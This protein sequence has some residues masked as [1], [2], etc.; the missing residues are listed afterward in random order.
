MSREH[1]TEKGTIDALEQNGSS[2]HTP[3]K[4]ASMMGGISTRLQALG[5]RAATT[6]LQDEQKLEQAG[7]YLVT[8]Y[9]LGDTGDEQRLQAM[10][11][12]TRR[13]GRECQVTR[14]DNVL[15]LWVK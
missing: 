12:S 5:I 1:P 2:Q 7:F 6:N 4:I 13:E 11:A 8:S 9:T 10:V 3:P 15:R 14:Q